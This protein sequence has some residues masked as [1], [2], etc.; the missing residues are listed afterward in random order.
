ME[1]S[2]GKMSRRSLRPEAEVFVYLSRQM[3]GEER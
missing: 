2:R 3:E 1:N